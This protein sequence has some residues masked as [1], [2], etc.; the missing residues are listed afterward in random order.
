MTELDRD[1]TEEEVVAEV[2]SDYAEKYGFADAEDYVFKSGKGLDADLIR[3]MSEMKN[4]PEWMLDIRLKAYEHFLERED[5]LLALIDEYG[6]F[7]GVITLE[8]VLEELLG[9]EIVDE[10][11]RDESLREVAQRRREEVLEGLPL[12]SGAPAHD[13]TADAA[14]RDA[15]TDS[16]S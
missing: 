16:A 4:E 8:D 12:A 5:H 14:P 10:T 11:D 6:G 2:N 7:A 1:L 9:K 3:Y 13:E 15:N